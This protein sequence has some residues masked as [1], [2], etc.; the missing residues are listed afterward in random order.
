MGSRPRR[1]SPVQTTGNHHI[2]RGAANAFLG[3][4]SKKIDAARPLQVMAEIAFG[5]VNL[6][7]EN[8]LKVHM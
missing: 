1:Y 5:Y 3:T 6:Y 4:L 7:P 2:G 8:E